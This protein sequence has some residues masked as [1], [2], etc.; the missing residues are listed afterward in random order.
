MWRGP[1]A[2]SAS[3]SS[4]PGAKGD[5]NQLMVTG[6]VMVG[7]ILTNKAPVTLDQVTPIARLTEETEAI[8]VPVNSRSRPWG[9]W[10][11]P[12]KPIPAR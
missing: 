10:P 3:P 9:I 2:P 5:P 11:P 12:S 1:A 8:A 4:S 6:Y 7:A